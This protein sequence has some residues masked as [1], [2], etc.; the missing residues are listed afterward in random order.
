MEPQDLLLEC[1]WHQS[2]DEGNYCKRS[3]TTYFGLRS[4][5]I[6][7]T[8]IILKNYLFKVYHM[9]TKFQGM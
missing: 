3:P 9:H 1:E 4:R 7:H 8:H 2:L 6:N 5:A